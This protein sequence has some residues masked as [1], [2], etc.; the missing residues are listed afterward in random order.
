M[1]QVNRQKRPEED[2]H[3]LY[4]FPD[5]YVFRDY[6]SFVDFFSRRCNR[7]TCHPEPPLFLRG[8]GSAFRFLQR[9]ARV[10]PGPLLRKSALD[11]GASRS[12]G[13]RELPIVAPF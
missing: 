10:S 7:L 4:K 5:L 3:S 9:V 6:Y 11:E 8:E 13:L 12:S 2:L 1:S